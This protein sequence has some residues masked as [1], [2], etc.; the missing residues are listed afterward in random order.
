MGTETKILNDSKRRLQKLK[1]LEHFFNLPSLVGI[2]VRTEI[3]HSF[4]E[5]NTESLDLN[6]LELFH[7]QYTDSLIELLKKIKKQKEATILNIDTEIT[8]HKE[9]ITQI[10]Q[11][12]PEIHSF[13]RDQKYHNDEIS[14][15]FEAA[16]STLT[17]KYKPYNITSIRSFPNQYAQEYFRDDDDVTHL[18]VVPETKLYTLEGLNIERLLL[19]RLATKNF[20]VRFMCGFNVDFQ[21]FEL[22]RI[23]GSDDEFIW[24]LQTNGFYLLK[25]AFK[26][27]LNREKN[28]SNGRSLVGKLERKIRDLEEK[29]KE[30]RNSFP[31]DVKELL[32][33]YRETIDNNNLTE[34]Q[35]NIEEEKNILTSMLD[36]NLNK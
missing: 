34:E 8:A 1:I 15:V 12:T 26:H 33:K 6:K 11:K 21:I 19:S 4:F 18:L 28:V 29:R 16:Y 10:E 32:A 7:L 9:Y 30:I 25:E 23:L 22:F 24:N 3:I 35:L 27:Q 31:E 14:A 5:K 13:E 20:K 36:L 2:V 17:G